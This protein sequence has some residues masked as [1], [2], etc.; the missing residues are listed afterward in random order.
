ME[1][2]DYE[3]IYDICQTVYGMK[4]L[5]ERL[6]GLYLVRNDEEI[7]PEYLLTF[8]PFRNRLNSFKKF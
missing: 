1:H 3:K 8:L 4:H 6:E 2:G 7:G 5:S